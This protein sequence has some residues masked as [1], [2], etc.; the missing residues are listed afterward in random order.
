M[1]NVHIF[2]PEG[3]RQFVDNLRPELKE[4]YDILTG[5]GFNV[6]GSHIGSET[7]FDIL[8]TTSGEPAIILALDTTTMP[9]MRRTWYV[10]KDNPSA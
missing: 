6:R 10:Y 9:Q 2:S 3:Q 7:R 1:A 4:I 5:N 8:N